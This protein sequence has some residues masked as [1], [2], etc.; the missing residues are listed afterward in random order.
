MASNDYAREA[1]NAKRTEGRIPT[2]T[3]WALQDIMDE[4]AAARRAWNAANDRAR[5]K[6]DPLTMLHL[7]DLRRALDTIERKASDALAG[8]YID[9]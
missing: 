7:S 6:M 1:R 2:K 9:D 5:G 4:C 3:G 8:R